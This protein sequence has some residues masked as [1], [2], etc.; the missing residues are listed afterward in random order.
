MTEIDF[1]STPISAIRTFFPLTLALSL[2]E[3]KRAVTLAE[4]MNIA[5]V[6]PVFASRKRLERIPL[7]PTGEGR[8]EGKCGFSNQAISLQ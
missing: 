1:S 2:V 4:P 7:L 5:F 3:R 8:G 6:N